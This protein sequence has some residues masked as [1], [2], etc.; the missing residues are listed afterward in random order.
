MSKLNR[1]KLVSLDDECWHILATESSPRMQSVYVRTA[2]V[3]YSR[4]RQAGE[5][6]PLVKDGTLARRFDANTI[7]M[8]LIELDNQ[9]ERTLDTLNERIIENVS[10]KKQ[11]SEYI[12]EEKP[13]L[14]K[15]WHF[16]YVGFTR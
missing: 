9:L 15:W 1:K 10:L 8:R 2:I 16:F 14:K 4:W 13:R 7:N 5:T 12:G 6:I 3:H 11:L